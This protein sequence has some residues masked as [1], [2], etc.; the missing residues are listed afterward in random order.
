[1]V[2]L[3]ACSSASIESQAPLAH[4]YE[5]ESVE[6]ELQLEEISDESNRLIE[7]LRGYNARRIVASYHDIL[8]YTDAQC[9]EIYEV[10]GNSVWY[11]YCSSDQG[12]YFDGYLFFNTHTDYDLFSDG[13][14]WDMEILSASSDISHGDYGAVHYGGNAYFGEGVN[15]DGAALFFSSVQGSF[16][17]ENA[18]EDWLREGF[19]PLLNLYGIRYETPLGAARGISINGSLPYDGD[20]IR[21]LSFDNVLLFD[22]RIGF[23]CPL[24]PIG[25]VSIRTR[26]GLWLDV[27]FDVDESWSLT[28]E[29]DGCG[30]AHSSSGEEY[31]I[32]LDV[33]SLISWEASPW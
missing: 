30:R 24:E 15:A 10:D 9:P 6:T 2:F 32:C 19:S 7:K 17:V 29:C 12:L 26:E 4:S 25:T 11:G 27:Q 16:L 22:E 1:M 8:G 5:V 21:A 23:P 13:S 31:D 18:D 28:G 3:I 14:L 33:H 20:Y